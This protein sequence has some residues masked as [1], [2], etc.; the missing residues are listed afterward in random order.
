MRY[1]IIN[2]ILTK[3][4]LLGCVLLLSRIAEVLM[5]TYAQGLVWLFCASII[6]ILLT[7]FYAYLTYLY[8]RHF[9]DV[10]LSE[11]EGLTRFTYGN[12]LAFV[13]VVSLLAGV[14]AS[15]G[16]WLFIHYVIGFNEFN[17]ANISLL[18]EMYS[19]LQT[20]VSSEFTETLNLAISQSIILMQQQDEPALI[21]SVLY[22]SW[23]TFSWG[24]LLGLII[25][26]F[27]RRTANRTENSNE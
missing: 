1:T 8:T 17:A 27:T 3:G 16:E 24:I 11:Y 19:I 5:I 4:A 15:L 10:T 9:A 13:A 6:S 20:G 22:G 14:V 21:E 23:N 18:E 25:A 2:D 12:G 7:L 26:A